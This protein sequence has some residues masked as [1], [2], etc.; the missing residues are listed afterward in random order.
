MKASEA[1]ESYENKATE[2]CRKKATERKIEKAIE[3]KLQ[4]KVIEIQK[5][6]KYKVKSLENRSTPPTAQ[7]DGP[8]WFIF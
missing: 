3:R 7:P 5:R 8:N 6:L 4:K 1:T 2:S